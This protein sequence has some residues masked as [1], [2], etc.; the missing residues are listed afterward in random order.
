V[1]DAAYIVCHTVGLKRFQTTAE[2]QAEMDDLVLAAVVKVALIK[3]KPDIEAIAKNGKVTIHTTAH[4]SQEVRLIGEIKD[5]VKKI[6]GVK[7]VLVQV[8]PV[9]PYGE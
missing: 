9:L 4:E 3:L 2:S 7:E 5:V 6:P 8:S 1:E